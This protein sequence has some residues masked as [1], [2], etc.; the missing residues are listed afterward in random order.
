MINLK[1][2]DES[3]SLNEDQGTRRKLA[4]K[5]YKYPQTPSRLKLGIRVQTCES[6]DVVNLNDRNQFYKSEK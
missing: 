5:L 4:N 6:S 1:N 3:G 2:I